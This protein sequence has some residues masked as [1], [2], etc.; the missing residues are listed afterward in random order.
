[1]RI[2]RCSVLLHKRAELDVRC[3]AL[4]LTCDKLRGLLTYLARR[5]N[6]PVAVTEAVC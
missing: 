3:S 1:M 5:N 6:R 4:R 2:T